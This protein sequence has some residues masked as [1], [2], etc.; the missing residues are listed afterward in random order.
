MLDHPPVLCYRASARQQRTSHPSA[1]H[2]A[3]RLDRGV[4][5]AQESGDSAAPKPK[6]EKKKTVV[7]LERERLMRGDAGAPRPP[8]AP[9]FEQGTPRRAAAALAERAAPRVSSDMQVRR[10]RKSR[11]AK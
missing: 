5:A 11:R 9:P 10:A 8:R 6:K 3:R 2:R 1:S 4:P 7:D